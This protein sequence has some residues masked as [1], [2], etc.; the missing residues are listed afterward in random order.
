MRKG[1]AE[2]V[3]RYSE[4]VS[5]CTEECAVL[6]RPG[7]RS[8]YGCEVAGQNVGVR[9]H[10]SRA[11]RHRGLHSSRANGEAAGGADGGADEHR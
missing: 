8:K 11:M 6:G 2:G 3:N 5:K 1:G 4:S 9:L 10:R 7:C